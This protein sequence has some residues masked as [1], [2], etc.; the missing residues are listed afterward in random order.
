MPELP[1]VEAVC[2]RLRE[3]AVGATIVHARILKP[4]V[5]RPQK[6]AHVERK[7]AAARID[8][9]A[10]RGKHI[11]VNL[12]NTSTLHI[13]LRMTGNLYTIPDIRLRTVYVRAY[14]EFEDGRGIVFEDPRLLG[15]IHLLTASEKDALLARI[16]REPSQM[17]ADEFVAMAKK[18][19]KP[20]K[21]LLL[22]QT[23]VSGLGNIY[24]A[25]S[26]FRAGINPKKL[27]SSLSIPRLR[28]LH[29]ACVDVLA[30]AMDSVYP[31]YADPG[32]FGDDEWFPVAVYDR[33]GEPC[34]VCQT[35]IRR[36][37]QGGRSTYFC[38]HCQ[39][40]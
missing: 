40:S 28:K 38:P 6:P 31:V 37:P 22:D 25:E 8:S 24:A 10:R 27:A 13:H 29:Q 11:L 15:K 32:R 9:V 7:A 34:T 19:R 1:E 16:A 18:A 21:L 5:T 39:R 23:R 4:S 36:I 2:R 3:S 12:D 33:E 17:T 26:L 14:F 35:P 20:V 30:E